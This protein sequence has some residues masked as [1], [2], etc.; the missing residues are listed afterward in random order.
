MFRIQLDIIEGTTDVWILASGSVYDT[1]HVTKAQGTL[2]MKSEK[3]VRAKESRN[4]VWNS[5]R[6]TREDTFVISS[7]VWL[8]KQDWNNY[9]SHSNVKGG[10]S[11]DQPLEEHISNK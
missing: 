1:T 4:L 3:I 8:T 10:V 7:T 5:S 9:N 6:N 2:M 11:W